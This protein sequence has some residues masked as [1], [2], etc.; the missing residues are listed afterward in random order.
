MSLRAQLRIWQIDTETDLGVG[1][2]GP[3]EAGGGQ[4]GSDGPFGSYADQQ[5]DFLTKDLAAVDRRV[6][7]V[8]LR[9]FLLL[10]SIGYSQIDGI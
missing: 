1:L 4:G 6:T 5:I 10:S 8:S 2:I 3:D 7:R 9:H